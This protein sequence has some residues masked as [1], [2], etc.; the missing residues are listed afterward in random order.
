[1]AGSHVEVLGAFAPS[2][3]PAVLSSEVE[4]CRRP[5]HTAL[6]AEGLRRAGL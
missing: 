5:E 4:F 2:F 1:M 3:L 6:L